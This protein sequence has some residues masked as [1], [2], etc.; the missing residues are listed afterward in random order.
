MFKLKLKQLKKMIKSHNRLF[1]LK[2]N[3]MMPAQKRIYNHID[4]FKTKNKL[5]NR[6]IIN[7]KL[8]YSL[9]KYPYSLHNNKS[10]NSQNN[11]KKFQILIF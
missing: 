3:M 5:L 2:F 1:P 10:H 9:S 4:R 6:Q 7:N 11:N 8:I